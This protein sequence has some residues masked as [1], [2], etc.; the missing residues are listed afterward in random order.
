MF[1]FWLI[2]PLEHGAAIPPLPEGDGGIAE[3]L[4]PAPHLD[5]V[6]VSSMIAAM[7]VQGRAGFNFLDA[8][9]LFATYGY[10]PDITSAFSD[11]A[12]AAQVKGLIEAA[13]RRGMKYLFGMGLFSW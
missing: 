10:P 6:T 12:R 7:D 3:F 11:K 1:D 5:E 4:W 2:P 13:A 9:G 8:W